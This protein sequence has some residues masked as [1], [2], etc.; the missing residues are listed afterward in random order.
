MGAASV[1]TH[2]VAR[3]GGDGTGSSLSRRCAPPP[4]RWPWSRTKATPSRWSTACAGSWL[5]LPSP[6]ACHHLVVW[7]ATSRVLRPVAI[8]TR[9]AKRIAGGDLATPVPTVGS[10][11]IGVLAASFDAMRG[12]LDESYRQVQSLY[13]QTK[14]RHTREQTMLLR[15]S[16][17][18]LAMADPQWTLDRAAG[19]AATLASAE[20]ACIVLHDE[21]SRS[22]AVVRAAHG[23][24]RTCWARRSPMASATC[25]AGGEPAP[26]RD[27][28]GL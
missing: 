7:L 28:G 11:E 22:T 13:L 8:L 18:I 19:V 21:T 4:G 6:S 16:E 23:W 10:D 15:F 5:R 2:P 12:K 17:D 27:R 1:A 26:A 24:G 14:T 3:G 25:W 20:F 9:S